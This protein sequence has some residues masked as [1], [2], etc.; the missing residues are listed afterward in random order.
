MP[1]TMKSPERFSI[2]PA[3]R[4]DLDAVSRLLQASDLPT[5]GIE[6]NITDFLVAHA[7]YDLVGVVGMEYCRD[8]GLLRSTAVMPE[9]RG[10]G[11]ARQLVEQI[12]GRAEA[13]GVR[14][15]YLLT[16]T[17]ESYFPSFG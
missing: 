2:R 6:A 7:G 10:K 14:A 11:V 15:L 9:W 4:T 13:R 8:Y 16:T 5:V 12:I 17:A 3:E 1:N